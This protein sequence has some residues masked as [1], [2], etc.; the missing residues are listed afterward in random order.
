LQKRSREEIERRDLAKNCA[1]FVV[2][3]AVIGIKER[4]KAEGTI[5]MKD[6]LFCGQKVDVEFDERLDSWSHG[7]GA[8][9]IHQNV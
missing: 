2:I 4:S 8:D 9:F 7:L 6:T 3:F 1:E 5:K